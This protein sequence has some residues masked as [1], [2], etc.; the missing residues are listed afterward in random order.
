M[1]NEQNLIRN[2]D[3]TPEQRSANGR[4]GGLA[5]ARKRAERR[6]MQEIAQLVLDMPCEDADLDDI[7]ELAFENFPDANLTV[8]QAAVLAVAKKAKRGDVAALQFLR[9]TAGEKP[10]EKVE[11]SADVAKASEEIAGMIRSAK[12]RDGA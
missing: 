9:D 2:E 4:K 1:A 6:G 12:E 5:S 10:V 8:G 11:V 3:L 7:R